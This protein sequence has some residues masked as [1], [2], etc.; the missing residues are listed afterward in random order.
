M[1]N[2]FDAGIV[3]E[4]LKTL[5]P[6]VVSLGEKLIAAVAVYFIGTWIISLL[7]KIVRKVLTQKRVD[8]AVASFVN[9]LVNTLLRV[10]LLIVIISIL[11][12][13]TTSFAAILAAAGL[14]IGMAMK[15]NLSNFAGGVM[16]LLN[17]PFKLG[18]YIIAQGQEGNVTEIGILYTVLLTADGRTIYLPNGPLSTGAI[19]N[20]TAQATRRVD[21][22]FNVYY[23]NNAD[24]LKAIFGDI[25]KAN[26]LTLNTP[27]PFVGITNVQN[28]TFDITL[29]AWVETPNYAAALV[30]LNETVYKVMT[31]KG[32]FVEPYIN[33][34]M[35]K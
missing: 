2:V 33:V 13:E 25:I 28:G 32:L 23:E 1:A 16:I 4:M 14:A 30:Q 24:E 34:K 21:I 17:K 22:T 29:R 27:E 12:I 10:I 35:A 15:D 26:P 19:T 20:N 31:D 9:S 18:D 7:R 11:G 5:I 6:H 3:S 8:G